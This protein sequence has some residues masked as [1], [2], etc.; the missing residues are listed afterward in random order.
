LRFN[1]DPA[2]KLSVGKI[3]CG[4]DVG[5]TFFNDSM[6]ICL[7]SRG[8]SQFLASTKYQGQKATRHLVVVAA[9]T[10]IDDALDANANV[11]PSDEWSSWRRLVRQLALV[12]LSYMYG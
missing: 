5:V 4:V 11:P 8:N 10:P 9:S 3:W 12:W 1:F 6:K 7:M 2:N